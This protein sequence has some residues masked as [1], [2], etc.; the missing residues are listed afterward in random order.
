MSLLSRSA[1]M[2]GLMCLYLGASEFI[3]G[4]KSKGEI[5]VYP[6]TRIPK[7]LK[8]DEKHSDDVEGGKVNRRPDDKSG[9][10]REVNIQKQ[11]AVFHFEDLCYEVPVRACF[12]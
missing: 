5:K 1:F 12:S 11:T 9:S 6:R 2:I 7:A 3:S 8:Q 10:D 4:A